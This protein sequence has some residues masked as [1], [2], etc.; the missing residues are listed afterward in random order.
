M[1]IL[2]I[3]QVQ[4]IETKMLDAVVT[5]LDKHAI[6]YYALKGTVV[7]AVRHKGFIPWDH[8]I[9]LGIPYEFTTKMVECL[10]KELDSKYSV[11]F[12]DTGDKY[13][14]L[15]PRVSLTGVSHAYLHIDL[16]PLV[17]ASDDPVERRKML[18]ELTEIYKFYRMKKHRPVWAKTPFRKVVKT[19]LYEVR[20][21]MYPKSYTTLE[22]EYDSLCR[23]IPFED[24]SY[25][26]V[27]FPPESEERFF[28][29]EWLQEGERVPFHYVTISIPKNYDAYLTHS[30]GDYMNFPSRE[31]QEEGLAFTIE[32]PNHISVP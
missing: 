12:H 19:I 27:S 5:I 26:Y 8:D 10:R 1:K 7:G 32:V 17:G 21:A 18:S 23:S 11:V 6:P 14:F 4:A 22:K 15:Y 3:Q 25:V 16:F 9:D 29:K 31:E 28:P 24:A 13:F 2:T 20:Q 30:Y